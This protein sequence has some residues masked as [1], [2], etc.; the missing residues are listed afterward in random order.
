MYVSFPRVR[1]Q[2]FNPTTPEIKQM[3]LGHK[4]GFQHDLN[5]LYPVIWKILRLEIA[6]QLVGK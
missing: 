5:I 3:S 4:S 2:N 6:P 1:R